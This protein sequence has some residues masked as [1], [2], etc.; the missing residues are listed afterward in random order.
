[1]LH[2]IAHLENKTVLDVQLWD[3]LLAYA[4]IFGEAK[5]VAK[6][7]KVWSQKVD[8]DDSIIFVPIMLY[9]DDWSESLIYNIENDGAFHVDNNVNGDGGGFSAGSSGGAGG[10][11]D[12]AF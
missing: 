2:D 7:M 5:N 11:S 8:T 1:M 4:I 12:G 10:G 6:Q 9:G 3:K